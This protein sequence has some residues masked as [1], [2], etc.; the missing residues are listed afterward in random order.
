MNIR[1]PI[2]LRINSHGEEAWSLLDEAF[3]SKQQ[4]SIAGRVFVTT[5]A[6]R[7]MED[8]KIFDVT[9]LLSELALVNSL[10]GPS[11][12]LLI[13]ALRD[14]VSVME[15]DLGG[16]NLI[17]PELRQA[18]EAL[19][20]AEAKAEPWDGE[21]MPTAGTVCEVSTPQMD[22]S[23]IKVTIRYVG[24]E[25]II[26][27]DGDQERCWLINNCTFYPVRTPEQVAAEKLKQDAISLFDVLNPGC[28]WH[29]ASEDVQGR[30]IAAVQDGYR[31]QV[32]P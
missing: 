20:A 15:R 9:A 8:G 2:C 6:S 10:S 32:A 27:H 21:S 17:Q 16:L 25:R 23:R 30:Y 31:K 11:E 19:A 26:A 24:E 4:I 12:N 18:R 5:N 22:G 7:K 13:T 29:K 3:K 14:C 1:E 28:K